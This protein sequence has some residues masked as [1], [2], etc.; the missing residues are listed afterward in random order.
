MSDHK[1][2][3]RDGYDEMGSVYD[4]RR[5]DDPDF[6]DDL[7][8]RVPAG[9]RILDAGCG[10]GRPVAVTLAADY[11]LVG[12]DLSREQVGLARERVPAPDEREGGTTAPDGRSA[13]TGG[14]FVQGDVTRLPFADES[15]DAVAAYHSVIHVPADEHP[16][17]AREFARVLR[18]D[19]HLLLTV[20]AGDWEGSNDDWLDTGVEMRWSVPGPDRTESLLEDSGF[21]VVWRRVTDDLLGGEAVFVLAR[22]RETPRY[23]RS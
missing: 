12:I 17:T 5:S 10:S 19:G 4:D 21:E 13:D 7:R 16:A 11:D 6:L 14:R 8:E 2:A 20:G 9:G 23:P 18:P 22:K 1:R 3:V 15:F